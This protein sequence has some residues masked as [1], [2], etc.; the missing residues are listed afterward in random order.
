MPATLFFMFCS[1]NAASNIE[2]YGQVQLGYEAES[3]YLEILSDGTR[4]FDHGYQPPKKA[5]IKQK[6]V[7]LSNIGIKIHED[8][9]IGVAAF[10]QYEAGFNADTGEIDVGDRSNYAFLPR[11]PNR[12][13]LVGLSFFDGQHKLYFG[14][15]ETPFKR[16]DRSPGMLHSQFNTD[17][18]QT[19]LGGTWHN[20]VFYDYSKSGW[21]FMGGVTTRGGANGDKFEGSSNKRRRV[22]Y[23]YALRY[24]GQHGF[25]G[26]GW[27]KQRF[28]MDEVWKIFDDVNSNKWVEKFTQKDGLIP[29]FA[30]KELKVTAGLNFNPV[31]IVG[32][33]AQ[34]RVYYSNL[35][36][37]KH[38]TKQLSMAVD[39]NAKN[40]V[41][42]NFS[43]QMVKTPRVD[44]SDASL[45]VNKFG[46][47]LNHHFSKRTQIYFNAMALQGA[48]KVVYHNKSRFEY[49]RFFGGGAD[50]GLLHT[51]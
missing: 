7:G 51:F 1:A 41:F 34:G 35:F 45:T 37:L 10:A 48:V 18:N 24:N 40:N 46:F 38:S 9:G 31:A 29:P 17:M 12:K 6:S 39:L 4:I 36:Y 23:G 21:D 27:Q 14:T 44:H 2:L 42:L 19:L 28:S 8:L 33:Y 32:S 13:S 20:A 5:L 22:S 15:A 30:N 25:L 3:K 49:K 43:S 11:Y 16:L 47:G 50:I 26:V